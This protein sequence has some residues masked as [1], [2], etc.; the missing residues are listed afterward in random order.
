VSRATY[1][2]N[3]EV[4]AEFDRSATFAKPGYRVPAEEG[5]TGT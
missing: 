5:A 2:P 3:P 1:K 4:E